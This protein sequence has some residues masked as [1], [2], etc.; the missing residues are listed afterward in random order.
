MPPE[1]RSVDEGSPYSKEGEPS[2]FPRQRYPEE[3]ERY[4]E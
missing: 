1:I 4:L 2:F 3:G